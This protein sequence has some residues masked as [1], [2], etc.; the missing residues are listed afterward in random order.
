MVNPIAYTVELVSK[1]SQR[2][3]T[4]GKR[5]KSWPKTE[6]DDRQFPWT[7]APQGVK[8]NKQCKQYTWEVE[9]YKSLAS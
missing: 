3:P 6:G 4:L 5:S 1:C 7:F 2:Q 8:E 9:K